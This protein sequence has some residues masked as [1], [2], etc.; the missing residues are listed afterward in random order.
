MVEFRVAAVE[1]WGLD[2]RA[3]RSMAAV[4]GHVPLMLKQPST[5]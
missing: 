2:E 1:M 5:D 4:D 3:C